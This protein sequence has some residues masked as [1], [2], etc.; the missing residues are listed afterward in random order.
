MERLRT[1]S[2][3]D[4]APVSDLLSL[5]YR[6]LMADAYPADL[7]AQ[8]LPVITQANPILLASGRYGLIEDDAGRLLACGGWSLERP[9]TGE[10]VEGLAH[11]RHFAVHPDAV[12]RGLGRMLYQW[13]ED[14]ARI[15]GMTRFEC[16]ASLNAEGFYRRLGFRRSR[17]FGLRL[18]AG[19]TLPAIEMV[20]ELER[21]G[22]K[23]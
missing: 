9:G 4:R 11:V 20:K 7:L 16:H 12:R 13:C 14:A 23:S 1:A 8:A 3:H 15:A 18:S 21:H 6:S 10:V 17:E 2:P 19:V 22:V 5:S